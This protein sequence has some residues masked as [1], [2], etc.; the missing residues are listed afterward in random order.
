M[1]HF[2]LVIL[3][4][5]FCFALAS[6]AKAHISPSGDA[7]QEHVAQNIRAAQ[8]L[9]ADADDQPGGYGPPGG[10]MAQPVMAAPGAKDF[11]LTSFQMSL[12]LDVG[13]RLQSDDGV[14][15]SSKAKSRDDKN[16]DTNSVLRLPLQLYD[17]I[18]GGA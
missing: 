13:I 8:S 11:D 18:T 10:P 16:Y 17:K 4:H 6:Q 12:P 1:M 2:R 9:L 14:W 5:S 15:F 3:L 7:L